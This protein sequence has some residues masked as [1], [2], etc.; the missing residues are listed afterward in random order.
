MNAGAQ[1]VSHEG[2]VAGLVAA[3]LGRP[4]RDPWRV[5]A[6]CSHG[7]PTVI[8]SPGILSD[9]TPFPTYAWLTCPHLVEAIFAEESAG[10]A[11]QWAATALEDAALAEKLR[12]VDRALR[13]ARGRESG[14]DDPCGAVG[15]AGQKDPSAVKCLHAHVA[16]ALLGMA[17][18]IGEAELEAGARV[19]ADARCSALVSCAPE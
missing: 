18:P 10:K 2:A 5:A 1:C 4:P 12:A 7:Y 6:L 9:G 8:V 17:D 14:D 13:E 3:Q 15:L 19:C 16:L 11:S